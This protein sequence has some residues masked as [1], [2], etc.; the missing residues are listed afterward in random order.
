[1]SQASDLRDEAERSRRL[2]AVTPEAAM[3]GAL[4]TMAREFDRDA[5]RLERQDRA[6]E[7]R[8]RGPSGRRG[9]QSDVN[10]PIWSSSI[11]AAQR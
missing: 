7:A 8:E 5:E 2:A 4:E 10:I 6:Q 9:S 1:M 3:R 11:S